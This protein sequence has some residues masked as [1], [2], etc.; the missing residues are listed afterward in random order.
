MISY[1]NIY[2]YRSFIAIVS[3][4]RSNLGSGLVSRLYREGMGGRKS[5][6]NYYIARNTQ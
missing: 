1:C 3:K 5:P 4:T 2:L 6:Y